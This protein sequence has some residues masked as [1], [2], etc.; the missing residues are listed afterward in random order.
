MSVSVGDVTCAMATLT[1]TSGQIKH[2]SSLIHQNN[3][4]NVRNVTVPG[5]YKHTS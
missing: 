1:A 2:I 4:P 3:Y 5:I